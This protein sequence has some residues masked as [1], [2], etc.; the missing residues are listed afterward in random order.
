[1]NSE[2]QAH[3]EKRIMELAVDNKLACPKALKLAADEKVPPAKIGELANILKLK[4]VGC[5][6]GCFK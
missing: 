3:L 4:I 6:L 5:Q 1:M 2:K